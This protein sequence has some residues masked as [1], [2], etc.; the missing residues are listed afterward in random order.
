MFE[1]FC[2][3]AEG[4]FTIKF[5]APPREGEVFKYYTGSSF[6]KSD[7]VGDFKITNVI[8]MISEKAPE[9]SQIS[10]LVERIAG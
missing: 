10:V 1:V 3:S 8:Y 7:W 5:P 2:L 6:H 4:Q 9:L